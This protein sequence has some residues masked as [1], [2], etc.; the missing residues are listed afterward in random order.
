[1][2]G[3][4]AKH[5]FARLWKDRR[6]LLLSGVLLVLLITSLVTATQNIGAL[7]AERLEAQEASR[8]RWLEQ[9]PR[10]PHVAAH[11]GNFAFRIQTPL[12]LFDD[13]LDSYTG[14][15]V[16]L[17]PHKQND[18]KFSQA[19]EATS[20]GRF[21]HFTPAFILQTLLPLLIIFLCFASVTKEKEDDTLRLLLLQGASM[22]QVVL[23]KVLGNFGAIALLMILFF[24]ISGVA[25]A[26]LAGGN[27]SVW[28]ALLL[29]FGAYFAYA[30]VF[31]V[32]AIVISAHSRSSRA[33]LMKLLGIWILAC[34]IVPKIAA[35][36]AGNLYQTPSQFQFNEMVRQDEK[37]G[38][39]GHNP[40]D[41]RRNALLKQTLAKYGVDTITKLSVNFDAI[42]MV[43]S[44]KYTTMVYRK[45]FGQVEGQFQKQNAFCEWIGLADPFQ[46]I[47]SCSMALCGTDYDHFRQ[48]HAQAEQYRLYFVNT[49]NEF[50]VTHTKTGDWST[51]FGRD[52]YQT[53]EPFAYHPPPVG[54]SLARRPVSFVLLLFWLAICPLL[55]H[56][57]RKIPVVQ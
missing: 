46:A 4:I 47:Q 5:E 34:I 50:M 22:R 14:T 40:A 41:S 37:N 19:Q 13:G 49:M 12:S 20:I 30:F 10:N 11:F 29:L 43:E 57:T 45:R 3:V 15:Y 16:Y 27:A 8:R 42:A 33:S 1:M 39:D 56:S 52:L 36:L 53:I 31:T 32:V 51:S 17:E 21:S 55:I 7:R 38:L 24:V 2:T 28:P 18:I 25:L 26:G 6:L 35:N 44:E 48:F 54:W 9:I 23:G